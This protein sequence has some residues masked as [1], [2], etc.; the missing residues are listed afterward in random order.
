[1]KYLVI[2]DTHGKLEYVEELLS[3]KWLGHHKVFVGDYVDSFDRSMEDQIAI[4]K[5]LLSA[6]IERD[7]V[8]CLIGNH[9]LSY[10]KSGMECSGRR[11]TTKYIMRNLK[12]SI[13]RHFKRHLYLDDNL[14]VTHAGASANCF[15]DREELDECL[16][17][18]GVKLYNIG[19]ARGGYSF[20]GGIFWCDFW[21]EFK[22]MEGLIQI[23]GHSAHRPEGEDEGIVLRNN[24]YNIDCLDRVTQVLEVE[25]NED[26]SVIGALDFMEK[27]DG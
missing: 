27:K 9:E 6:V 2:G 16:G 7:D 12:T 1:M 11:S 15:K 13:L 10:I 17:N 24:C 4:V 18:D 25:I 19:F 14:L 8:T 5:M 20:W 26:S 23:V 21:R 22:E 3:E